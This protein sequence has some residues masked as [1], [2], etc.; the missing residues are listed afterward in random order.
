[1]SFDFSPIYS[2]PLAHL[3]GA[4]FKNAGTAIGSPSHFGSPLGSPFT[5]L[6]LKNRAPSPKQLISH[7]VGTVYA[8]AS[9]N[10][11]LIAGSKLGL[12]VRTRKGEPKAKD[13]LRV[14]PV[15]LKTKARLKNNPVSS[16]YVTEDSEVG[17][18][19]NHPLLDLLNRPNPNT[20]DV[21]LSAFDLRWVTQVSLELIGRAY[22]WVV[23]DGLG[24]PTQLWALRSHYVKEIPDPDGKTGL[25]HY[26]YGVGA[27]MRTFST[28]E[29][30][31]FSYPDPENPYSNG[32]SPLMAAIEKALISR[33]EDAHIGALLDNMGRPDAIWSPK[34]DSEGGGIGSVEAG[35]VRTAFRHAF[36]MA[37]RG[38]LLVSETPGTLEPIQW[39][40][41]DIVEINRAKAI[42][43]DI[44]NAFGVPDAK[45][46]RNQANLAAVETADYAHKIDAGV[47]R[48]RRL[49]ERFNADLVTLF[50]PSGRMFLAH[51]LAIP[52]DKEHILLQTRQ[53]S[54]AG[55]L[56]RN[57]I[58]A[59]VGLAP[60]PWGD[61]PL[62]PN[63]M[64]AVDPKTG[65]P[66][67]PPEPAGGASTGK[68]MGGPGT[69]P[70]KRPKKG[71][72][73]AAIAE[74][75]M[76]VKAMAEH[77]HATNRT[78]KEV[79]RPVESPVAQ[80]VR[81][82][83]SAPAK[84]EPGAKVSVKSR[85]SAEGYSESEIAASLAPAH[86]ACREM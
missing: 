82:I 51:D 9:L 22:W 21:G 11:D 44:C 65:K 71:K 68:P 34:G 30:I 45:L 43:T 29:I 73:R 86:A 37:G 42:K 33:K 16:L 63:T 59:S 40:P 75:A 24:V 46:E 70:P 15:G 80:A 1:M 20:G 72:M 38:G 83:Q 78:T 60:E 4:E 10:A 25:S 55:A 19:T 61:T 39:S 3:G 67:L 36:N 69:A 41:Q 12:Y 81:E 62:V 48:A 64:V 35:R 85:L 49:E 56:T 52:E 79:E 47:P 18:I 2:L 26:E 50:D 57:E 74:M 53:A 17:Q 54:E 32:Y 76:A 6:F 8:C 5:D 14:Q 23:R 27:D 84:P 28:D 77:S 66:E 13:Y 7:F 31:R 58:R